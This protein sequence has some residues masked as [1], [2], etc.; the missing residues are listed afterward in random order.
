MRVGICFL[1]ACILLF[2]SFNLDN[3]QSTRAAMSSM[4]SQKK[5]TEKTGKA[6]PKDSEK[7]IT[8]KVVRV[9]QR[10]KTFVVQSNGKEST[11]AAAKLKS[12][13]KVGDTL[14]FTANNERFIF[15]SC[16]ECNAKCPGVCFLSSD[17]CRCYLLH[18]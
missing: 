9:N 5:S 15:N 10:E 18:L 4:L 8:G 12:L 3:G 11:V 17:Y 1:F 16:E 6:A 13:P 14:T 7:S 2:A